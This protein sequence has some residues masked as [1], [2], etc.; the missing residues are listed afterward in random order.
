MEDD[1]VVFVSGILD[2]WGKQAALEGAQP[3]LPLGVL[4]YKGRTRGLPL[5]L[6]QSQNNFPFNP[7]KS[8]LR[9]IARMV[10]LNSLFAVGLLGLASVVSAHPG[11]DVKAE[12]AERASFLKKAPLHSRSLSQ[13]ASKLK[14]RGLESKNVARRAHAVR[15]LR[16]RRGIDTSEFE[17]MTGLSTV[18]RTNPSTTVLIMFILQMPS[19]LRLAAPMMC[20]TPPTSRTSPTST[21]PPTRASCSAPRLP[22]FWD[23]M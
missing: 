20:S 7:L 13:C 4:R 22:A 3:V 23:L 1:L 8:V 19:S 11:H 2:V 17:K 5:I 12:A 9:Y 18:F 21:R 16:R 10:Q 14:V 6:H 15:Q